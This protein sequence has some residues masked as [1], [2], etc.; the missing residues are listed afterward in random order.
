[1]STGT[2]NRPSVY[3]KNTK[4]NRINQGG[5]DVDIMNLTLTKEQVQD[6]IADLAEDSAVSGTVQIALF[7]SDRVNKESGKSFPSTS[8]RVS[9]Y[10]PS[11]GGSG[12]PANSRFVPKPG[13]NTRGA[14]RNAQAE[15]RNERVRREI[16]S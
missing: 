15:A 3:T 2:T 11:A 4:F 5:A 8:I 9:T 14:G 16:E 6:L 10:Q 7:T 12:V 1:M 13:A